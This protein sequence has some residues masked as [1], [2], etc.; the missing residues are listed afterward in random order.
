MSG[1]VVLVNPH[2]GPRPPGSTEV[3]E[4]LARYGLAAAIEVVPDAES[5]RREVIKVI[6]AGHR[7]VVAGGDGTVSMAVDALVAH[8]LAADALPIGVLPTGTGCDL[9]RT[10]GIP[11]NLVGA[12]AHLQGDQSYR[13]DV[14]QLEGSWGRCYFVNVA[15]AGAGAA[16]AETA[17][18]MGRRL[19]RLRYPLAFGLRLPGFRPSRIEVTGDRPLEGRALAVIMANGQFFAGGWNVA[20]KAMLMDGRLDVQVIDV[21]KRAA[22]GLVPKIV[23]GV[24]L[25]HPGVR[26]RSLADFE[27]RTDEDWPL[28]ADGDY[29]GRTPVKVSVLP[30]AVS[31]KI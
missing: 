4:A 12:A 29:L 5:M 6:G 14:G 22:F 28:E 10:F 21:P 17:R 8:G 16:A 18:R 11:Q 15:Q 30:E 25:G 3:A 26:R 7:L 2:A 27:L 19:G 23:K 9:M 20:P 31:I 1:L 13:I 24:H